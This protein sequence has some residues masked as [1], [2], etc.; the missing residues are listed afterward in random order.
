MTNSRKN[1]LTGLIL[2]GMMGLASC[3]GGSSSTTYSGGYSSGGGGGGS[4]YGIYN[5]PYISSQ[6]FVSALNDLDNVS[7]PYDSYMVK[8]EWDTVRG[9]DDWF[10]IYDSAYGEYVAVSLQY[11]RTLEYYDYYSTNE[12]TADAYRSI[13]DDDEFYTGLIGDGYGDDY[14]IVD[15]EYTDA[16]GEDYYRGFDSGMLY[17][18]TDESTD[19]S[20][21]AKDKEEKAFFQKASSL[22]VTYSLDM[23]T[24]L[25][26]V[27]LGKKVE[28]MIESSKGEL[29]EADQ[30]AMTED[31]MKL[32]GVSLAE[33]NE[34]MKDADAKE[35]LVEKVADKL[36]TTTDS[37]ETQIL[38]DLLGIEI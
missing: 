22:S 27:S 6:S 13:A 31:V 25:S 11:V 16:Y 28:K 18:D 37:L 29:T 12:G 7:Y 26:L 21:Q 4:S 36:G 10:V 32:T 19:V 24:S 5:S 33:L 38:P 35:K 34:A 2:V 15:Y 8:D 3:N 30:K 9:G 14:E 17:E 1:L 23:K 20:L